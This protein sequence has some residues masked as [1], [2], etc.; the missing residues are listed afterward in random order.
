MTVFEFCRR[1]QDSAVGSAL[2]ESQY[3]WLILESIHVLSLSLSVGLLVI[4]DLRLIGKFRAH[5]P[6]AE[7]LEE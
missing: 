3:M 6:A 7:L 1:L 4:T 2:L 5:E